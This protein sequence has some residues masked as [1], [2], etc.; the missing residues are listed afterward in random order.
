MML[1]TA[2]TFGLAAVIA[3]FA[4]Q[5]EPPRRVEMREMAPMIQ[6]MHGK[7]GGKFTQYDVIL[8]PDKNEP[9]WWAGAPSVVRDPDGTFWMACRMRTA[10]AP[11]GLRG[12]EIRILRSDDGVRFTP[13][14]HIRREDVPI[15]GFERPALLRDP[16]TGKYKLYGCGPWKEGPWTIIKWDDAERPDQF[17]PATARPVIAPQEKDYER[18][19]VP[20]GYKDP[21][22]LFAEGA[23]H[24][25]VIGYIRQNERV[26]HFT[27][28]D[29]EAWSPV[30]SPYASMMD[31]SGWHDF[32]V[33]PSCVVPLGAG[34]L[35]VYEGSKTDWHDPVYNIATGLAF[36]F[37]LHHVM[38]LTPD[39]PLALSSTPGEHFATFRYSHWLDVDGELWVYA[40]VARPNETNEVR[41]FRLKK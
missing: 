14:H 32:F 13:V 7:I 41:L 36:T 6:G 25:Y 12:Y 11:R 20:V 30:G 24:C 9:E 22:I 39:Q 40:E 35:F 19:I 18:D 10:D 16:H 3:A 29:G 26:F 4:A 33:R 2:G 38:D 31:L 34:Y 27:S 15:P 28:A 17:D 37:D 23:W 8:E 5:G 1:K 21:F